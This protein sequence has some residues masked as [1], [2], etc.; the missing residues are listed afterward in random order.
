MRWVWPGRLRRL[1]AARLL[2]HLWSAQPRIADQ[3]ETSLKTLQT[4]YDDL[5]KL[6][7]SAATAT[8]DDDMS[9]RTGSS[10]P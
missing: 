2:V 4:V 1:Q 8:K 9:E 3:I 10:N 5:L 7:A 6:Q